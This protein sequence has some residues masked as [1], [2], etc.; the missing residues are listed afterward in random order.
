MNMSL[1][2]GNS[3]NDDILKQ[4]ENSSEEVIKE[5]NMLSKRE[6][7]RIVL[8]VQVS[9]PPSVMKWVSSQTRSS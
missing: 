2:E 1:P 9:T 7:K 3:T 8:S 5:E 4:I 6:L